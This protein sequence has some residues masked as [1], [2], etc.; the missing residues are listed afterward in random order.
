MSGD[1]ITTDGVTVSVLSRPEVVALSDG[2][3]AQRRIAELERELA[4]L[5]DGLSTREQIGI[6]TGLVAERLGLTPE[7]AFAVLRAASQNRNIKLRNVA[8]IVV[9][10]HCG[11]LTET[12]RGL[13]DDLQY[14]IFGRSGIRRRAGSAGAP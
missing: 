13:A 2:V 4:Q 11:R 7:N 12:E 6:A 1:S 5:R 14:L 8:K 10:A 3:G 9:E